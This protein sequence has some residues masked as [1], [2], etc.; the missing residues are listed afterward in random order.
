MALPT[1]MTETWTA[2]PVGDGM[3]K[4]FFTEDEYFA[5][6]ETA[7]GRWEFIPVSAEVAGKEGLGV[8][9]AMSGGSPWHSAIAGNLIRALGNALQ[10]SGNR[11]CQVHT[12][13][14]KVHCADGLNTFPDVSV[15]CGKP[16][17]YGRRGHLV[18]NPL[19]IAEVLSPST[20]KDD[21]GA[22]W[23]SYQTIPTLQHYLLVSVNEPRVEVFTRMENNDGWV[24][25]VAEG[26]EAEAALPMLGIRIGLG[27]LYDLID[28]D[29]QDD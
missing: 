11:I 10:A 20:E 24:L 4:E 15:V 1:V 22:K 25:R 26:R 12:S 19:L 17:R 5:F 21:R 16:M 3:E 28:F 6:E 29:Q 14:L 2:L 7:Y 13:D 9:R 8:M 23:R 27:D 18:T